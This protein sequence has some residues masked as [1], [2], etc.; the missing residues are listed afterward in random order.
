VERRKSS[1]TAPFL[2]QRPSAW[3]HYREGDSLMARMVFR[4]YGGNYQLQIETAEDLELIQTLDEARWVATSAP[5]TGLSCDPA[6]LA[7]MDTDNNGRVRTDEVKAAQAWLFRL[8]Q[9]R[10]RVTEASDV[11][12]LADVDTSHPEGRKLR[13]SAALIL[14]NLNCDD[15][16]EISLGQVRDL[17]TIMSSAANNGDGIIP[18]EAAEDE[19]TAEFIS[20]VMDSVGSAQDAGGKPGVTEEHINGFF[21]QARAYLEWQEQGALAGADEH[22]EIMPWG[23]ATTAAYELIADLEGKLDQYFM[24]CDMVRFDPRA[25]D[26][27]RLRKQELEDFDFSDHDSMAARLDTAPLA[28]PNPAG[29]LQL[30]GTINPLYRARLTELKARVLQRVFDQPVSELTRE[31]WTE[32]QTVFDKYRAWISNKKGA[33]VEK[34]GRDTLE[35]Y[36]SGPYR[37]RVDKLIAADK[38][39]AEQLEQIRDVEKLILYQRWLLEFANNFVSFPMLYDPERR[40]LIEMGTLVIDGRELTFTIKVDDRQTHKSVAEHS[41]MYLLYVEVTGK[42]DRTDKFEVVAAVTSG[43]AGGLRVGKRGIFFT[44]DGR[45]WDAL[46]VDIISN[47]VSFAEF[48]KAPF[49]QI[50]DFVKG[51]IERFSKAQQ[52]KLETGLAAPTSSAATRDILLGGSIAVAALGSAFAYITNALSKVE[53][54]HVLY[55]LLG[56]AAVAIVPAL[57]M[58]FMKLRKRDMA[59]II[60]A[61][62]WAINIRMKMTRSL[63]RIFT[64]RPGLPK[65]A[66]KPSKDLLPKF[67][68]E[69]GD[70]PVSLRKVTTAVLLMFALLAIV[71]IAL[72]CRAQ[73]C[74]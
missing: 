47:P 45:E 31:Q 56:I 16:R 3:L 6:F 72:L 69:F 15:S 26:Q 1:A 48:L 70:G 55:V 25:G 46:V 50:A 65:G 5:V 2:Q 4:N 66:R 13:A 24:Q 10:D 30:E 61:S 35:K 39:A 68:R 17:E 71:V 27:M 11:V 7:Y 21:E 73:P 22:T 51:Q 29:V 38:A 36:L 19:E 20:A 34:L 37:D 14:R 43:D 44:T 18:P 74:W 58:G 23:A 62:G 59:G 54:Y 40:S 41:Y 9:H 12:R 64:R 42:E 28:P 8:L 32:V 63:G 53:P 57:I 52:A 33:L 60:E 67:A 49:Q